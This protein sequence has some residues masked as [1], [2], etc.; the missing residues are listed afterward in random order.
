MVFRRAQ[1]RAD[2]A[3]NEGERMEMSEN[4]YKMGKMGKN[5]RKMD[6]DAFKA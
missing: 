1:E 2:T 6:V 4:G 3:K 5:E